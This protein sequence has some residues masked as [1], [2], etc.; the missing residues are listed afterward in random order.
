MFKRENGCFVDG[1]T[2]ILSTDLLLLFSGRH[3]GTGSGGEDGWN[4]ETQGGH[5]QGRSHRSG[6]SVSRRTDEERGGDRR[7]IDLRNR[8]DHTGRGAV[9]AHQE[10][11]HVRGDRPARPEGRESHERQRDLHSPTQGP[12]LP[13]SAYAQG[14]GRAGE[15][16]FEAL[17]DVEAVNVPPA[18]TAWFDG[19]NDRS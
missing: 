14:R 4:G 18:A 11:R 9:G 5:H 3:G 17:V 16:D 6:V 10:L 13:A 8:Q 15:Q 2:P 19:G 1:G 7:R 12:E